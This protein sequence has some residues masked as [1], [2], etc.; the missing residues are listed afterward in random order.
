MAYGKPYNYIRAW[1]RYNG[2]TQDR[3]QDEID[4]A[5]KLRAPNNATHLVGAKEWYLIEDLVPYTRCLVQEIHDDIVSEV[6]KRKEIKRQIK[7]QKDAARM[8]IYNAKMRAA[9]IKRDRSAEIKRAQERRDAKKA[10]L[11]QK[12]AMLEAHR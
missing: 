12:E 5:R 2:W 3:L 6:A 9:G 4:T 11:L 1:G 8:R 10:L 7:R